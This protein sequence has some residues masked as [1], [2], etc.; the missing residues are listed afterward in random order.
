MK[1]ISCPMCGLEYV[2]G[3]AACQV[4][5][6]PMSLG[7][8]H[9][10]HCPRCGHSM[11][12]E[13]WSRLARLVRRLFDRRRG[14]VETLAQLEPGDAAE[15]ERLDGE[16]DMLTSLTAQGVVPGAR[17]TLVQRQP[18]FVIEVGETVLALERAVAEAVRVRAL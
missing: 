3:G 17:V 18:A 16:G 5:G 10:H 6:C 2:P 15:V 13:D 14:P 1:P 11:P 4:S 8:C 7:G 9:T 12:D